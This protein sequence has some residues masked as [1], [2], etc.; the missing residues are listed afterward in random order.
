MFVAI[1]FF[2][3]FAEAL[4]FFYNIIPNYG[5]AIALLTLLV[6]VILTP[7]TLK[8]TRSMMIMQSL[9]PEMKKIQAQY[10]DDRQKLN[11]ELLKFYRENNINPLGGCIPLLIQLPVFLILYRVIRGLTHIGPSGTIEP[12]YLNHSSKLYQDLYG[13]TEM[14]AFGMNL[15][16]SATKA[17]QHSFVS[18]LPYL[19]LII[20]VAATSVIQQRQISGRNPAAASNPQQQ[21]L[22]KLGPIM[23]TGISLVAPGGL[24]IY[25]FVSNL[26][27]VGQQA[28]ISRTIYNT[29][30][31]KKL[32]EQQHKQ[33]EEKK[34]TGGGTQPKGFLQRMLGDAAPPQIGKAKSGTN[35]SGGKTAPNNKSGPGA[36][37]NKPPAA[38]SNGGR[39]TPSGNR[40]A[41]A[42]KKKRRK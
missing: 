35:G 8:G 30:E 18:V 24:V 6:M 42:R 5:V 16:E 36:G 15:A 27:R 10:K 38:K 1:D 40:S 22:M 26:Y 2:A 13:S 37:A 20:G 23:I 25:F 34:K 19:V 41:A 7:L 3:P 32:L 9:Q 11:E 31:A 12:Q 29:P 21:M 14:R 17:L 28:L 4:A 33:A 39:T